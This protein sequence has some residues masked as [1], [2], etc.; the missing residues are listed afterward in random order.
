LIK[1]ALDSINFSSASV[2]ERKYAAGEKN[3]RW[4]RQAMDNEKKTVEAGYRL[5][6]VQLRSKIDS[7]K[8]SLKGKCLEIQ[9]L[10]ERNADLQLT[11]RDYRVRAGKFDQ[12][13]VRRAM[14]DASALSYAEK[15]GIR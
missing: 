3:M 10:K 5:V 6:E 15:S 1:T 11:T 14:H 13:M 2:G 12:I 8:E 7:L 9:F 4:E